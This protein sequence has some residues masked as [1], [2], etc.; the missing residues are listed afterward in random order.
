MTAPLRGI[1]LMVLSMAGFAVEDMC[2]KLAAADLPTGEILLILGVMGTGFFA[3][4]CR[5]QGRPGLWAQG[6]L[7]PAVVVRNLGEVAGTAGFVLAI[8]LAEL[9]TATAVFQALPLAVTLGAALF[10][11]E[12]VG[13]RRWTAISVGFLGVLVVIRPGL[14]GFQPAALWS[15]LAVAAL[16]MRD[17][18]TRK[19]PPRIHTLQLAGW[20]M[21]AVAVLGAAMLAVTGGA[22]L[23]SPATC[24]VLGGAMTAG[25]LAYWGLTE[26]VRIA[27]VSITTPFRYI[28]LVFALMIG[29]AVFGE[30]P[31]LWTWIGAGLIVGSGLYTLARER[32]SRRL[33]STRAA[34]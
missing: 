28:R 10:L 1:L 31:D 7:H 19:V 34:G 11:G 4:L 18:A 5:I 21:V 8:T 22:A 12:T 20:G 15:V 6:A 13:W 14:D 2:I 16:A 27:D 17:L 29:W 24:A 9:T 30:R 32:R 26:A 33:S 3:A 25:F 23:P